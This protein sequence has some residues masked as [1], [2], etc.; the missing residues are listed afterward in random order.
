MVVTIALMAFTSVIST[1]TA[2]VRT[3]YVLANSAAIASI[4]SPVADFRDSPGTGNFP[5]S[6][7]ITL[8]P[9]AAS[10]SAMP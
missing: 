6:A 7:I 4:S 9:Q 8:Q 5:R 2:N 10:F 3:P 1:A